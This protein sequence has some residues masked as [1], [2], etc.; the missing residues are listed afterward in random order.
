MTNK[1]RRLMGVVVRAKMLKTV[2]VQVDRSFR[3]RV[4]QK[5]IRRTKRYLAHDEIGC[6]P[7][8]QVIIV[9]SRPLSRKKRWV[10]QEVLRRASEAEVKAEHVAQLVE[11]AITPTEIQVEPEQGV[12]A[13][14][15]AQPEVEGEA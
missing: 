3:H 6:Q 1:R 12:E 5:V 9:E 10:V 7:G 11:P 4:Y 14:A 13:E 2:T 15:E 8:D